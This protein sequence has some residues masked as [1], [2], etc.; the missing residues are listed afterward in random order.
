MKKQQLPEKSI[1]EKLKDRG[2]N[3]SR[4]KQMERRQINDAKEFRKAG[5]VNMAKS[6]EVVAS[7]LKDLRRKV[8]L[9]K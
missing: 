8:C 5:F 7:K 6:E 9:L 3:C 1:V 2:I 4:L